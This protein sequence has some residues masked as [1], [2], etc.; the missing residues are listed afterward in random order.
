VRRIPGS[1]EDHV[2]EGDEMQST[3]RL[4]LVNQRL[5][6]R[7]VERTALDECAFDV[8]DAH[9]ANTWLIDARD[10]RGVSE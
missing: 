1:L 10:A 4:D 6:P 2:F 5:R 9:C 8:V 3:I 7:G